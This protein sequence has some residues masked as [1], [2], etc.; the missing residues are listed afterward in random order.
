[1]IGAAPLGSYLLV[2]LALLLTPGPAVAFVLARSLAGGP[3]AGI[4]SQ[5]GLCAGLLVHVG[6]AALGLSAVL[7]RSASALSAIRLLGAVYLVWLALAAFRREAPGAALRRSTDRPRS[8]RLFLDGFAV[9]ALNPKPAFFFLALLPQFVEPGAG[10]AALQMVALGGI[11]VA[12]AFLTGTLYAVV[13]GAAAARLE[14][15]RRL[16]R[17]TRWG[18]GSI[19]LALATA[20]VASGR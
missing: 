18:T 11:F 6:A 3:K 17:W 12:L 14:G 10:S 4:V 16:R 15:S 20:A 7:M 5:T 9:D 2:S 8:A 19:Y 13:A 1:M